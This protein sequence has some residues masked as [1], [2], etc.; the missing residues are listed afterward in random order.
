MRHDILHVIIEYAIYLFSPK[1]VE[2]PQLATAKWINTKHGKQTQVRPRLDPGLTWTRFK[3]MNE[4]LPSYPYQALLAPSL[5]T[6]YCGT[7]LI[8]RLGLMFE[9]M[10]HKQP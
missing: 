4:D 1:K 5:A 6:E 7:P 10:P 8:Y 3:T 9:E 2:N